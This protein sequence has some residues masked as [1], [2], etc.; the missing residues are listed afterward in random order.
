MAK[1]FIIG[2]TKITYHPKDDAGKKM[3]NV[4]KNA[5]NL[6]LIKKGLACYETEQLFVGEDMD[7]YEL[8]F[9]KLGS[10]CSE[11][12]YWSVNIERNS[13]GY[14]EAFEPIKHY[15]DLASGVADLF[16]TSS[17]VRK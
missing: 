15:N 1:N 12:F 11:L 6:H 9:D 13:K 17:E 2:A 16:G 14:L 8:L 10:S 7:L 5:V 4:N 3:M